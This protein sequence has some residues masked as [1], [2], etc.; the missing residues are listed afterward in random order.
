MP[1]LHNITTRSTEELLQK[2]DW[3]D[4]TNEELTVL[5]DSIALHFIPQS[6]FTLLDFAREDLKLLLSV[7]KKYPENVSAK[8]I[9]T[10]LIQEHLVQNLWMVA[11]DRQLLN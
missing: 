3:K 9:I 2:M 6:Y 7:P 5:I 1:S 8:E 10:I 4:F 11:E